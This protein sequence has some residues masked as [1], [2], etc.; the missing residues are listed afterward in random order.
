MHSRRANRILGRHTDHGRYRRWWGVDRYFN[1]LVDSNNT[2]LDIV[3]GGQSSSGTS[4]VTRLLSTFVTPSPGD[5]RVVV[6]E[7]TDATPDFASGTTA[8][9]VPGE[10]LAQLTFDANAL[11]S[12]CLAA[13]APA[14]IET[15]T[16]HRSQA[17][18]Y[19][20]T[21][22]RLVL[23]N[24]ALSTADA[25][26]EARAEDP[27]FVSSFANSGAVHVSLRGL[28]KAAHHRLKRRIDIANGTY[29][30]PRAGSGSGLNLDAQ[31]ALAAAFPDAQPA[32]DGTIDT[33][34]ALSSGERRLSYDALSD[35]LLDAQ[36]Y[37]WNA[38][39]RGTFNHF[40]GDAF[41]GN[42][43]NGMVGVDYRFNPSFVLG[44]L[45][46]Y[47]SGDFDFESTNGAF[48]GEGFT[49]GA[50]VG[51]KLS[52]NL[53]MSGFVAHSWLD[54][55]NRSGLAGGGTA[56]GETNATR[57]LMSLNITGRHD[58]TANLILEPNLRLAYAHESQDAYS[59]SDGKVI[60]ANS[61]DSGQV[62]LGPTF[63][64][65]IPDTSHGQWSVKASVHGEYDL[66]S[67]RQT[68]TVLPDF[69]D[70]VTVRLGLGIDG[71]LVNG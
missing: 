59:A 51:V 63:R 37:S 20:G 13:V 39:M 8:A 45:A 46:G 61:I 69:D 21:V 31:A 29:V 14:T 22:T 49:T 71:T 50:Y 10:I 6:Y 34:T 42:A 3:S 24:I 16:Q 27:G 53:N 44:A 23:S 66:S 41:S 58:L 40:D 32:S 5:L 12:D 15:E 18:T 47:E 19:F 11:D 70:L 54:Y 25:L 28:R 60:G 35:P 1:Y 56:T 68:S 26:V 67:E 52:R 64:Y 48:E 2:V 33:G 4:T 55:D 17:N 30:A 62:S 65:L 7:D 57:W 43:W 9:F 36:Q 38:W